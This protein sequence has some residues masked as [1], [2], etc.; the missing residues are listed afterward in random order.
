MPELTPQNPEIPQI[1]LKTSKNCG[2]GPVTGTNLGINQ[3]QDGKTTVKTVTSQEIVLGDLSVSLQI[4]FNSPLM[5]LLNIASPEADT[6][7]MQILSPCEKLFF[8]SCTLTRLACLSVTA[9]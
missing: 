2:S 7:L 9:E 5:P 8:Q 4:F 3:V 6:L 1:T